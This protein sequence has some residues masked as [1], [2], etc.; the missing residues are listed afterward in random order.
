MRMAAASRAAASD[1]V[2]GYVVLTF[3]IYQEGDQYVSEC[4]E[5]RTAS[6]GD[7]IEEAVANIKEATLL[8][9]NAI[10]ESGERERIF[11]RR[12]IHIY[13]GHPHDE[14]MTVTA[15]SKDMVSLFV[16]PLAAVRHS[17][18]SAAVVL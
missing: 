16:H 1:D 7:S 2:V 12:N 6:C 4:A 18:G 9:L 13:L 14:K 3:R 15:S 11:R 10:E 17:H 8:Y 5:L